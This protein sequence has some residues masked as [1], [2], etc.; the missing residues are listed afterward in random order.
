MP[1]KRNKHS[2]N[3]SAPVKKSG[4][5]LAKVVKDKDQLRMLRSTKEGLYKPEEGKSVEFSD[6]E[7]DQIE[8]NSFI[9]RVF[10]NN[11]Q[12]LTYDDFYSFNMH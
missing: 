4:G 3:Q 11:Q 8:I 10:S 12:L 6:R 9:E 1:F 5:I 2:I 7:R